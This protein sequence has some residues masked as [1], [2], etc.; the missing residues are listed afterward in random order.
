MAANETDWDYLA[1][2]DFI[3]RGGVPIEAV[4]AHGTVLVDGEGKEWIDLEAAN[5]SLLF[6]YDAGLAAAVSAAWS[7]LPTAPSFI[8]TPFRRRYAERLGRHIRKS[9]GAKGRLAFELGGGQGIE[10]AIRL[11]AFQRPERR[12]LV[13]LEGC[14]HGRT[15][16][17]SNLSSSLR[18]RRALQGSG[19]RILRLPVPALLSERGGPNGKAALDFCLRFAE[20]ALRD[21]SY[22]VS[23]DGES[24]ALALLF[25]PVLNVSGLVDPTVEYLDRLLELA[26]ELGCLTIADEVFT[27]CHRLGPF[28]ASESLSRIPDLIVL[29]KALTNGFV[30][31]SAV[32]A[33]GELAAGEHFPPGTHSTTFAN[34]PLH[35][36]A[37]NEVLSRIESI[38]QA[39]IAAT[40]A[41]LGQ[42]LESLTRAVGKER[43][44]RTVLRGMTAYAETASAEVQ[45]DTLRRLRDGVEEAGCR[46]G[47]LCAST[48]LSR[49]R[50]L[51]HPPI[52]MTSEETGK[53][54]RCIHKALA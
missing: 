24:D 1:K 53:T 15:L 5:G 23:S 54:L 26:Q 40:G 12:T 18:Y 25:E 52:N 8:E 49:T 44:V 35:F 29:S 32:W 19:Y 16:F 47:L 31:L 38:T 34:N 46:V 7:G 2:G 13:V 20:H 6:G 51:L 17:L 9:L 14:Y 28:L 41:F 4:S 33:R 39:E 48:G 22:G 45:R 36:V 37:A 3:Y 43:I 21:Q 27:G 30:P 10:L 50:I 11:A 42:V